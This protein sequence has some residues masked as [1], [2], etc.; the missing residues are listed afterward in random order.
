[1]GFSAPSTVNYWFQLG[2]SPS[3]D[4]VMRPVSDEGHVLL[5]LQS[6]PAASMAIVSPQMLR[7]LRGSSAEN[8]GSWVAQFYP[9]WKTNT[10]THV[11]IYDIIWWYLYMIC[12]QTHTD[13]HT[14]IYIYIYIRVY[15]YIY[16]LYIGVSCKGSLEAIHWTKAIWCLS[17]NWDE[18]LGLQWWISWISPPK[19]FG[20]PHGKHWRHGS[21]FQ[22]LGHTTATT[23][24]PGHTRMDC[25]IILCIYNFV[26][27]CV[28]VFLSFFLR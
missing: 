23:G 4:L 12:I 3:C 26:H 15:I 10:H 7:F 11:Q 13:T 9:P 17:L 22:M 6:W 1:M 18:N 14:D 19:M 27:L 25:I 2:S 16:T 20:F 24:L 5:P 28:Y 21:S 8:H